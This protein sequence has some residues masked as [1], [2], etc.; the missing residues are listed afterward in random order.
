MNK[1]SRVNILV[2]PRVTCGAK[3]RVHMTTKQTSSGH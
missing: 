3:E 1:R 2:P